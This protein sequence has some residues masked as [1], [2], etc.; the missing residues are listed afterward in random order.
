MDPG[1]QYEESLVLRVNELYHDF[2]GED[3]GGKHDDIFIGERENWKKIIPTVFVD[4]VTYTVMEVGV[5]TGFVATQVCPKLSKESVYYCTD[6]SEKILDAARKNLSGKYECH[7][8]FKKI[9]GKTYPFPDHS[10]DVVTINSVLH[11][12]PNLQSFFSEI[13]RVLRPGGKIVIGH[14]PNKAFFSNCFLWNNYRILSVIFS[15]QRSIYSLCKFLGIVDVVKRILGRQLQKDSGGYPEIVRSI[16]DVLFSEKRIQ[17]PLS[18]EDIS[19]IIDIHSPTAGRND[20]TR[21][22]DMRAGVLSW[23]PGY[24]I[25]DFFSYNHLYKLSRKNAVFSAYD[26]LLGKLFPEKGAT[27]FVVVSKQ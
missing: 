4:G 3:Y 10:V 22:I 23:L 27:F 18:E 5:G 19:A 11:H 12:I 16:N 2:E 6:I 15:P 9:D 26:S 17:F 1:V 13:Q 25:T 24:V 7:I 20:L 14:E 8:E 21:G